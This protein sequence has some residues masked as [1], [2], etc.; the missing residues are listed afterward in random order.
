MMNLARTGRRI[1]YSSLTKQSINSNR[2]FST[3]ITNRS[4][5]YKPPINNSSTSSTSNFKLLP[6]SGKFEPKEPLRELHFDAIKEHRAKDSVAPT[7]APSGGILSG[8]SNLISGFFSPPA[9]ETP[10]PT[11]DDSNKKPRFTQFEDRHLAD[12]VRRHKSGELLY[13]DVKDEHAHDIPLAAAHRGK[14]AEEIEEVH[15]LPKQISKEEAYQHAHGGETHPEMISLSRSP[16]GGYGGMTQV[17]KR[18]GLITARGDEG[19]AEELV[20][21]SIHESNVEGVLTPELREKLRA[22]LRNP[23]NQKALEAMKK[24]KGMN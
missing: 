23:E 13:R 18:E 17:I 19:L 7:N 5:N 11:A 6:T 2:S 8:I 1:N 21:H 15:K 9:K 24:E 3:S 14:S 10:Q 12:L 20:R 22:L 16:L 4:S